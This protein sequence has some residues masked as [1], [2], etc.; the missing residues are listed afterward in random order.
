M[1]DWNGPCIEASEI[2]AGMRENISSSFNICTFQKSVFP[3][4]AV[5]HRCYIRLSQV[6]ALIVVC[7]R[8]CHV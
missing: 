4:F 2:N 5:S 6:Y 8:G 7:L 3:R 1:D